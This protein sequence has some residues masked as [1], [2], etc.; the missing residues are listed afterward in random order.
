MA[1]GASRE[2]RYS[3]KRWAASSMP[4]ENAAAT[5]ALINWCIAP[6]LIHPPKSCRLTPM[7]NVRFLVPGKSGNGGEAGDFGPVGAMREC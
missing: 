3:V 6:I 1:I 7:M 4:I 2:E 5:D